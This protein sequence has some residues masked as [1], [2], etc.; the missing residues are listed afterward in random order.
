MLSLA[1]KISVAPPCNIFFP[2]KKVCSWATFPWF[3]LLV[4]L[5]N[6]PPGRISSQACLGIA[7]ETDTEHMVY[8][9]VLISPRLSH[10]GEMPDC[11][12]ESWHARVAFFPKTFGVLESCKIRK[13]RLGQVGWNGRIEDI[14]PPPPG[15]LLDPLCPADSSGGSFSGLPFQGLFC[16]RNVGLPHGT[17]PVEDS[18]SALVSF[19]PS[20]F[21]VCRALLQRN[22]E[23]VAN[24]TV[25]HDLKRDGCSAVVF[26]VFV[27][28]WGQECHCCPLPHVTRK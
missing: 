19:S 25:H 13:Q 17:M 8:C 16:M 15:G 20:V 5:F 12:R 9:E 6:A 14:P 7:G 24:L 23:K 1:T 11:T 22:G 27:P 2:G 21:V 3:L 18:A 26:L 10:S 28:P 4:F